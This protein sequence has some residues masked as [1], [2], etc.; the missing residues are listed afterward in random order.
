MPTTNIAPNYTATIE[1]TNGRRFEI[2]PD[3]ERQS[4]DSFDD[5]DVFTL[6]AG[7]AW[8]VEL[9]LT[10]GGATEFVDCRLAN[11]P[12]I[13]MYVAAD[14]DPTTAPLRLAGRDIGSTVT[15]VDAVN[16]VVK[17]E[18]PTGSLTR[19]YATNFDPTEKGAIRIFFEFVN[20]AGQSIIFQ[21]NVNV[22][23]DE[24][25]GTGTT[26]PTGFT[27]VTTTPSSRQTIESSGDVIGLEVEANATQ[28]AN[29]AQFVANGG[30]T[31]VK[32][33]ASGELQ[34][35]IDPT[36]GAGVG[37]RDY[38][39][40][41]YR[42]SSVDIVNA[43]MADNS[44]GTAEI[45]DDAVTQAKMA[46][47]SVGT[48]ELIDDAVT[49]DKM[50]LLSV[51]TPE[52]IDD[53]VTNAKI[54]ASAVGTTELA[55]NAVTQ[56]KIGAKAVGVN[57]IDDAAVGTLQL[58]DN[59]VTGA[60]LNASIDDLSDVDNTGVADGNVLTWDSANGKY[61]PAAPATGGSGV[62]LKP[63]TFSTT[64][65]IGGLAAGQIRY[66]N[67]TPISVTEIYIHAQNKDGIDIAAQIGVL[68]DNKIL[69]KQDG[70]KLGM[71]T[72]DTV[73]DN[74]DSTYTLAVTVGTQGSLPDNLAE[75]ACDFDYITSGNSSLVS[76]FGRTTPNIVA[77]AGDYDASQVDND[78]NVTGATVAD[79]L[80]TL[81]A[82]S[83]YPK[84]YVTGLGTSGAVNIDWSAGDY[85]EIGT[86]TGNISLTFSNVLQ[87]QTITIDV[88][89]ASG[90][91]FTLP[92]SVDISLEGTTFTSDVRNIVWLKARNGATNQMSSFNVLTAS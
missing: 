39:D 44:V 53:S 75:V 59:S 88:T 77:Q 13:N 71:F 50:G 83:G 5:Y 9:T 2:F 84:G 64:T 45:V 78:S 67:V 73:T 23:D 52:L 91:T 56:A 3:P 81:D 61:E 42:Q 18:C 54:G 12:T 7:Q 55:S 33:T 25:S 26:P 35:E 76:V 60:K 38:N 16:G 89:G 41:R 22:Q 62:I 48:P 29:I 14:E 72:V 58:G 86:L 37:D 47:L 57:E 36:T 21:D 32:V 74:L 24:Y 4:V 34:A 43:D 79:A 66:N 82:S 70:T 17:L 90:Y 49:Q 10:N 19:F 1:V 15:E 92:A 63:Y 6:V 8:S 69:I 68:T 87:G 20:A 28:T 11:M 27:A 65:T 40:A 80:N 31:G 85:F 46:L 51:G 30:T